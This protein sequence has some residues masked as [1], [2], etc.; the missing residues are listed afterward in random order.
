MDLGVSFLFHL[1][2]NDSF[3]KW[4]IPRSPTLFLNVPEM[5]VRHLVMI[6]IAEYD[7]CGL[8]YTILKLSKVG[9]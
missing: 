3:L 2:V 8:V 4:G 5:L 6:A 9:G 1:C 7:K